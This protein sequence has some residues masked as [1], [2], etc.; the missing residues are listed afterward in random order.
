[1][2]IAN[3]CVAVGIGLVVAS[4]IEWW[5]RR[6]GT[7][8]KFRLR[9]A[10]IG[11]VLCSLFFAWIAHR[12]ARWDRQHEAVLGLERVGATIG[13]DCLLPEWLRESLSDEIGRPFD[14]VSSVSLSYSDVSDDDLRH[15]K[16]LTGIRSLDLANTHVTDSGL[17]HVSHCHEL[18]WLS[19]NRTAITDQGLIHL[20]TMIKLGSLGLDATQVA[21]PGLCHLKSLNELE[22]LAIR[23]CP[24][25]DLGLD[26]L[27]DLPKLS[28]VYT[29]GSR[30][31]GN[32]A[33]DFQKRSRQHV[34]VENYID[35]RL[36]YSPE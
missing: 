6:Y 21:G 1:M 35:V 27:V 33:A 2:L 7:L 13:Y 17:V 9:T 8:L 24:L 28:V 16:L 12:V 10:A 23:D 26:Y 31:S 34:Y 18:D 22:Y 15:L 5:R 4:G 30:I 32:G 20:A 3:A 25:T 19:L 14:E 11:V 36:D 29:S